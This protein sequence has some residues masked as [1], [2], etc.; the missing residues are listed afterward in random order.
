MKTASLVW[1]RHALRLRDH[2][3]LVHAAERGGVIPVFVWAPEEEA[4][5]PPGGA[6]CWWLH[7]ALTDLDERLRQRGSRLIFRTG[8]TAETLRAVAEEVGA[9]RVV[10][11]RR[12]EPNLA[13]RD[14]RVRDALHEAGLETHVAESQLLHDPDGGLSLD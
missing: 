2:P 8:P 5:W 11:N 13:Q 12:Y 9:D 6:S 14:A 7:H 1:L 10:W 3:A 4:P